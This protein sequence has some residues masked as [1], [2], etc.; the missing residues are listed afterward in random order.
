[1]GVALEVLVVPRDVRLEPIRLGEQ[2]IHFSAVFASE[3][4]LFGRRQLNSAITASLCD[5]N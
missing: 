5:V 4:E 3:G 2:H 1:M